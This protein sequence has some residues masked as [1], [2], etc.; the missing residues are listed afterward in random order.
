MNKIIIILI[1]VIAVL[2]S[3]SAKHKA[4]TWNWKDCRWA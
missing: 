3:T 1:G 4:M 2:F